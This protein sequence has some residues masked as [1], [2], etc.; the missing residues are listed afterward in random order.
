MFFCVSSIK[1]F[2]FMKCFKM[3][4]RIKISCEQFIHVIVVMD[5]IYLQFS[6]INS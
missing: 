2:L 5:L 4:T 1:H 3:Y 6:Y